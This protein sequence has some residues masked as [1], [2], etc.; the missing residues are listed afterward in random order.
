MSLIINGTDLTQ[1]LIDYTP[2]FEPAF[3][4]KT[5]VSTKVKYSDYGQ[6]Y[7]VYKTRIT[8]AMS[9]YDYEVFRES[10]YSIAPTYDNGSYLYP[11]SFSTSEQLFIPGQNITTGTCEFVSEKQIGFYDFKMNWC[12]YEL[13]F[14]YSIPQIITGDYTSYIQDSFNKSIKTPVD[15][16]AMFSHQANYVTG[17]RFSQVKHNRF[18]KYEVDCYQ[19][20]VKPYDVNQILNFYRINR[21]TSFSLTISDSKIFGTS[22]TYSVVLSDFTFERQTNGFYQLGY[23]ITL[24]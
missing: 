12:I 11:I 1:Y 9:V 13:V 22:G 15:S 16:K 3:E 6:K 20:L 23:T 24:K 4:T 2:I 18:S 7:D 8:L 5:T 21:S 14:A 17:G 19:D 10:L